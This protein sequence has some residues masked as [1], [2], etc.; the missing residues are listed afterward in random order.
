MFAVKKIKMFSFDEFSKSAAKKA[1]KFCW[2]GYRVVRS[3]PVCFKELLSVEEAQQLVE[4]FIAP[5]NY[6]RVEAFTTAHNIGL[7][8]LVPQNLE[9]AQLAG[10]H[11]VL[12]PICKNHQQIDG[13]EIE[14]RIL[15]DSRFTK[16]KQP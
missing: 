5:Q 8:I 9:T 12:A 10:F 6:K 16:E 15:L 2:K 11:L 1:K 13:E 4:A 3:C 14:R 7:L